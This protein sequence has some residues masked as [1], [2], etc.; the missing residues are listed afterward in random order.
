MN[1]PQ[2]RPSSAGPAA[3]PFPPRGGNGFK[4]ATLIAGVVFVVVGIA[5]AATV[6]MAHLRDAPRTDPIAPDPSLTARATEIACLPLVFHG[7]RFDDDVARAAKVLTGAAKRQYLATT[8]DARKLLSQKPGAAIDC[9]VTAVGVI[10][11]TGDYARILAFMTTRSLA[12]ASDA[13]HMEYVMTQVDGTW[14][15]STMTPLPTT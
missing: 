2:Y 9:T 4:I 12:G 10:S 7:G 13:A 3:P 8:E 5:A 11:Q 6:V 14:L 1:S 15:I